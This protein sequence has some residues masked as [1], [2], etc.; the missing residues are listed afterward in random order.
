MGQGGLEVFALPAF[1]ILIDALGGPLSNHLISIK[2]FLPINSDSLLNGSIYSPVIV[3]KIKLN[4]I[5]L[6]AIGR[7]SQ[8][9]Y[10]SATSVALIDEFTL[11]TEDVV[12][13]A[14]QTKAAKVFAE[15][16]HR[17]FVPF[18]FTDTVNHCW[19]RG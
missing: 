12:L 4:K 11:T 9:F 7:Q 3:T 13:A 14:A 15:P 6:K 18:A 19:W 17:S 10:R 16:F 2:R 5:V 1:N 8:E